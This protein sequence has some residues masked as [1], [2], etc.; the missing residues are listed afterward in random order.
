MFHAIWTVS[1]QQFVDSEAGLRS[2]M[3]YGPQLAFRSIPIRIH[4]RSFA[5]Q[6]TF[7]LFAERQIAVRRHIAMLEGDFEVQP[8]LK[9]RNQLVHLFVLEQVIDD[10][11]TAATT[12]KLCW[13]ADIGPSRGF[14]LGIFVYKI[15]KGDGLGAVGMAIHIRALTLAVPAA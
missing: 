5:Q 6:L 3:F 10:D 12:Q 15:I 7:S 14:T 2:L 4:L 8:I 13:A 11:L 1:G 9:E